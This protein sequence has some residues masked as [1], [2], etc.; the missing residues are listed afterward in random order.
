MRSLLFISLVI[1]VVIVS[2]AVETK[3]DGKCC[4]PKDV[5]NFWG[6]VKGVF[7]GKGKVIFI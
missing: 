4:R 2:H 1:F 3:D 6:V 7:S 5:K